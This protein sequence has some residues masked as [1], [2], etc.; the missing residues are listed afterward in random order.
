M[1]LL[2]GSVAQLLFNIHIH[3]FKALVGEYQASNFFFG[4]APR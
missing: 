2:S 3:S 1:K 4:G